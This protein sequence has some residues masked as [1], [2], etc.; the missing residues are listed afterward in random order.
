MA[1]RTQSEWVCDEQ[2]PPRSRLH[3]LHRL[4]PT[5]TKHTLLLSTEVPIQSASAGLQLS[6]SNA[7]APASPQALY[8]VKSIKIVSKIKETWHS[9]HG[10]AAVYELFKTQ[11]FYVS[12]S[13]TAG[14]RW[15][16]GTLIKGIKN[17]AIVHVKKQQP[18]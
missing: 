5:Y 2:K 16:Q 4:P 13:R 11:G 7:Q 12:P 6:S 14:I 1:V 10:L 17:E 15:P 9:P 3:H 8:N 18:I